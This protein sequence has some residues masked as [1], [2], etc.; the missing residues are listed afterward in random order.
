MSDSGEED[1]ILNAEQSNN[2]NNNN[3]YDNDYDNSNIN[4]TNNNDDDDDDDD[5]YKVC[6]AQIVTN[7]CCYSFFLDMLKCTVIQVMH[8]IFFQ[9]MVTYKL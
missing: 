9:C 1:S 8:H 3:N 4:T 7:C 5:V 2:D 6:R